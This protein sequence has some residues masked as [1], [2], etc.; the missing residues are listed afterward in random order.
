MKMDMSQYLD[1]FLEE[2][3]EHLDS[4]NDRLLQLEKNPGN[5]SALNEIFRAAHTLKGMA[6]TMGFDDVADLTHHME[7]V[8]SD[9]KESKLEATTAVVDILFQCFDRLQLMI[10]NISTSGQSKVDASDLS[11]ALQDIKSGRGVKAGKAAPLASAK[12][13][14]LTPTLESA[15]SDASS[16]MVFKFN[17]YDLTVFKEVVDQGFSLKYVKIGVDRE[18]LMKSVRVFMI[19]KVLEE[20]GEV[21]K[22]IPDAQELDEGKFEDFFEVIFVAKIKDTD[23]WMDRVNRISEVKVIE[24]RELKES[25]IGVDQLGITGSG[26]PAAV[27]RDEVIAAVDVGEGDSKRA[28]KGKQTVRVDI[29][30][31]DSL[32]NLVGELVMHKGRLEQIGAVHRIGDLNETIEQIDRVSADLQSVVMKVRMV[33]IEQVFNRFPRMVRDLAKDLGKEV[34]FIMEG[35]ETELDRTVIDEIGD[36]LVHLLRN[37]LDHGFESAEERIKAG[38]PPKGTLMLRAR[39]EGNNVYIEVEDDGAGINHDVVLAKAIEKGLVAAKDAEALSKAE[40]VDFLFM[41]GFSTAQNVTDVSGRG[42]GLDVVKSKIESLNGEI[43]VETKPGAGTKFRVKLPLTLAIIQALMVAV[44]D[45]IYAVPLS[46][47][48]ETTMITQ[49]EIKMIQKQEVITLRGNVLP[50]F[51]LGELIS[52]PGTSS[53]DEDM[54]VVIVRKGEKQ[55]GI[56]VDTLI[57]QQEIVIKSLGKLLAGIPGIAGAIVSGDGNVRLI[58]DISTL[59]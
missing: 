38:K 40:I 21:L 13:E 44:R 20:Y 4:L 14:T 55:I 15:I 10:E 32:M 6:S 42:V 31:L 24:S 51:R 59:F 9:L 8:L 48:D 58:L 50:L 46:S 47:V 26:E 34:E 5:T 1:V 25:E 22:S 27:G 37:A 41:S 45:E 52:V 33:P 56:M 54:Y 12:I 53:E 2:S 18:C 11:R 29:E 36:P 30:R 28:Y 49:N 35:K 57:G 39:H 43:L 7:D 3:K 17:E 19:F 16:D 23:E